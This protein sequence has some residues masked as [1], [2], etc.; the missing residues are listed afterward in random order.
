MQFKFPMTVSNSNG[1]KK[2]VA[3]GTEFKSE[4]FTLGD[5]IL[6]QWSTEID[7]ETFSY[8]CRA[9]PVAVEVIDRATF[10]QASRH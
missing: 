6:Y 7:G 9:R 8:E 1:L 2:T 5:S 3:A 10:E 4:A